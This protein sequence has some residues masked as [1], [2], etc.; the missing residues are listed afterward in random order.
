LPGRLWKSSS[1]LQEALHWLKSI[2]TK[3]PYVE[4][5]TITG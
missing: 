4:L 2:G 3:E 1:E 5:F